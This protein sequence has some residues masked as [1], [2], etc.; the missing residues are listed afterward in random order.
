[1]KNVHY[2]YL[3]G[4]TEA[5]V[6]E[7]LRASET[8]V[9]A[10]ADGDD[11]YAVPVSVH[12]DGDRIL[13]RVSRHGDDPGLKESFIEATETATFVLHDAGDD[14]WSIVVR[15]R[16]E[17]SDALDEADINERFGPFHV[18]DENVD[19]VDFTIYELVPNEVTGRAVV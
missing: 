17:V 5:E 8:G 2:R 7:R 9:L 16:L 11:A 13:V 12:Y 10:L 15:G 1:M 4:M 6:E 3:G 18:F 19:E 14:A